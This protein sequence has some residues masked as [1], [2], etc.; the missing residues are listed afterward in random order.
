[1][2]LGFKKGSAHLV[3]LGLALLI[4]TS[5][6]TARIRPYL[7]LALQH[8]GYALGINLNNIASADY[9]D[10][11]KSQ[12]GQRENKLSGE[13]L[14]QTFDYNELNAL[15]AN[16]LGDSA[17][18]NKKIEIDI[19]EQRLYMKEGDSTIG[20]FLVS[21]GKWAPTPTG[22]FAVWTKLRYTR[23]TGGSKALNTYYDLPNVPYVM[24]FYQGYGIHGA[25][26]HNNFGQPMSH[27]CVNMR[28]EEAGIVFNWANVGTPVVV[29]N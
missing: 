5:V 21:T 9:V 8:S 2:S 13:F 3:L 26:W 20:T 24:Y 22:S 10:F 17:S 27:G 1:M 18:S 12:N 15:Q 11:I 7:Y 6:I 4:V 16:V 19:S 25:Y 23:M 29:Y 28:P 14:N